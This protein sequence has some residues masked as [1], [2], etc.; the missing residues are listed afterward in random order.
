MRLK[1]HEPQIKRLTLCITNKRQ[2]L[3][4]QD[5]ISILESHFAGV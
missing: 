2:I 3:F 5:L 4:L 1:V